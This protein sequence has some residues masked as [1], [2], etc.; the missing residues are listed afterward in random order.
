[1]ASPSR[2]QDPGRAIDDFMAEALVVC[3]KCSG[4][5]RAFRVDAT[6]KALFAPRRLVCPSCGFTKDWAKQQ[7]VRQGPGEPR[8]DHFEL[9][10]W[11]QT[12]CV[13][14][15]LW[16]YNR[17]HLE[18]L[19]SFVSAKH[20]ERARDDKVGWRN[21]SLAS[22]LPKW[23]QSAKNRPAILQ[24]IERLRDRLRCGTP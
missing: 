12:P 15:T 19:E 22:R 1:M 3:P 13:G 17:D 9:P 23:I 2:F 21:G 10:L 11:L 20:R 24:A 8:D 5:A 7:I 18:F 4:C 6:A 14:E 16:A